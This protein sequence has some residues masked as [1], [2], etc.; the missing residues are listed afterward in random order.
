MNTIELEMYISALREQIKDLNTSINENNINLVTLNNSI[1]K[2]TKAVNT[3]QN[4]SAR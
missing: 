4:N 1:I 3:L 2:L